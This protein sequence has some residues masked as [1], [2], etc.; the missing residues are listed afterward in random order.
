MQQVSE[1][2]E[3]V[4]EPMRQQIMNNLVFTKDKDGNPVVDTYNTKRVKE[5]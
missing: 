3:K 2:Q 1:Y 5:S 4:L